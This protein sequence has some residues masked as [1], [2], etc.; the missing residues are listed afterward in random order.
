MYILNNAK[1]N[2]IE[3]ENQLPYDKYY[4]TYRFVWNETKGKDNTID[5]SRK[6]IENANT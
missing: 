6:K 5:T 2:F 4:L 1:T 3:R